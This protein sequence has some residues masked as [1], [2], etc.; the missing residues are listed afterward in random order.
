MLVFL[1]QI[2]C[3]NNDSVVSSSNTR[4]LWME[5]LRESGL[6]PNQGFHPMQLLNIPVVHMRVNPWE[7]GKALMILKS[8]SQQVRP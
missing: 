4:V 7:L 6:S 1:V 5:G 8:A 3:R 2:E